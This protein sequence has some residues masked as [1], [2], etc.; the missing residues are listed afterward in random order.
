MIGALV[1]ALE[2][3]TGFFLGHEPEVGSCSTYTLTE[4]GGAGAVHPVAA[5]A[6]DAPKA[7]AAAATARAGKKRLLTFPLR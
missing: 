5:S 7:I 4:D 6:G 2:W 3:C 1:G